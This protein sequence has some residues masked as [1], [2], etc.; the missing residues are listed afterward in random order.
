MP[1]RSQFL[2]CLGFL[3]V[4]WAHSKCTEPK[5]LFPRNA[6]SAPKKYLKVAARASCFCSLQCFRISRPNL[7]RTINDVSKIFS[8]GFNTHYCELHPCLFYAVLKKKKMWKNGKHGRNQKRVLS[9]RRLGAFAI[10]NRNLKTMST[11]E[12]SLCNICTEDHFPTG[13][14]KKEKNS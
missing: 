11:I 13:S 9:L 12:K 3:Y 6:P 7:T 14:A 2:F 4:M 5:I 10:S 8:A 1:V